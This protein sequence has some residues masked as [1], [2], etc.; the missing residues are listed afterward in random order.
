MIIPCMCIV[1]YLISSIHEQCKWMFQNQAILPEWSW[2]WQ[3]TDIVSRGSIL[4]LAWEIRAEVERRWLIVKCTHKKRSK[5]NEYRRF[6]LYSIL[7]HFIF[8][9][10]SLLSAFP[11]IFVIVPCCCCVTCDDTA[12]WAKVDYLPFARW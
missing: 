6:S 9:P 11:Y 10:L 1:S 4:Y 8:I 7:Y 12:N 2:I 3:N 5:I